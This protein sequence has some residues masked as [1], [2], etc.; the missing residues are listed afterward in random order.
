MIPTTAELLEQR[1]IKDIDRQQSRVKKQK[2]YNN[3]GAKS[4]SP[5]KVGDVTRM[6]PHQLGDNKLNKAI[7]KERLGFRSYVI[8]VNGQTYRRNRVDLRKTEETPNNTRNLY[9]PRSLTKKASDRCEIRERQE[10]A[11]QNLSDDSKGNTASKK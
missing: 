5:L 9:W 6:R 10:L 2:R 3:V 4:L 11:K 8:D 7:V 1:V